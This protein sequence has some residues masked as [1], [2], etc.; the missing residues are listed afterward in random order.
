MTTP[1]S[2]R[3]VLGAARIASA[4]ALLLAGCQTTMLPTVAKV[5]M[6][7]TPVAENYFD[8]SHDWKRSYDIIDKHK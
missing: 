1:A 2:R 6:P 8:E 3:C 7:E 5:D 4:G